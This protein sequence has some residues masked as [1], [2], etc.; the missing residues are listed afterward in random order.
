MTDRLIPFRRAGGCE[1]LNDEALVAACAKGDNTAL[2]EL[3]QR[4][5][6]RVYRILAR[7]GTV[8]RRDLEDVLQS[9][10]ITVQRAARGFDRRSAVGTWVVGIALHVAQ[11]HARGEA[12]RRLAMSAVAE[13][14]TGPRGTAPDE[15][16]AHRQM[17]AR[18]VAGFEA[19]PSDLRSVFAL[20]ELEGMRGADAARALRIPEGT[21][22]RR[23]HDARLRLRALVEEEVQP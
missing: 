6:G 12:R 10:F 1:N 15:N 4:H 21:V 7:L 16:A 9:T 19:L 2:D 5:G 8:D 13:V 3:F 20:C 22:W 11:R 23:L 14:H 17:M 18:L